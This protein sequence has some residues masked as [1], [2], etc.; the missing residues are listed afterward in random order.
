M[1]HTDVQRL[2]TFKISKNRKNSKAN[3]FFISRNIDFAAKTPQKRPLF[4]VSNNLS[5]AT[6]LVKPLWHSKLRLFLELRFF[7]QDPLLCAS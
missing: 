7:D 4:A 2:A 1:L 6:L 5:R 3:S